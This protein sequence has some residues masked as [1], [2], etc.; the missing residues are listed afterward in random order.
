MHDAA[1]GISGTHM[2]G[3]ERF[4]CRLC[5]NKVFVGSPGAEAFKFIL[6]K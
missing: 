5:G 6:D 2:S 4:E 1:H 3:S